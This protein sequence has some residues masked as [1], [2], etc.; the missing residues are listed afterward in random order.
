MVLRV[1]IHRLQML[2]EVKSFLSPWMQEYLFRTRDR[3]CIFLSVYKQ[4]KTFQMCWIFIFLWI[5][6]DVS[7]IW[8]LWCIRGPHF[9][10]LKGPL[11][12]DER[13]SKWSSKEVL[14]FFFP[15]KELGILNSYTWN[16][17][18]AYLDINNT[19]KFLCS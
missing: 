13:I 2:L 10:M 9:K 16:S 14:P 4:L 5:K 3:S 11:I 12:K 17:A 1:Q 18:A 7:L 15:V 6:Q 19:L 8:G